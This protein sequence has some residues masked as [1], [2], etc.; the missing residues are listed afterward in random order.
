MRFPRAAG[1]TI[2]LSSLRTRRSWG[3]GEI[4]DLAECAAWLRTGGLR[5]LQILPPYELAAGE[6]SPYGAR[7]AFGLDPIYVGLDAVLDLDAGA[8]DR[9][10]GEAGAAELARLRAAPSVEFDAVRAVKGRVLAAAFERFR[11][12]ELARGTDR[13]KAFHAFVAEA[14]EW[15]GD[16]ALYVALR[17]AHASYGWQTWP[18]GERTREPAALARAARDHEARIAAHHY[19]QWIAHEQ[20]ARARAAMRAAGVELMGDLPFVVGTESAD[21]WSHASQ[22]RLG[23]SLG[24]PPDAFSEEGQDWGL[25][26]YDWRAMDEDGLAWLRARTRHAA[27]L[28]DRFRLDHVIGY[29][30]MFVKKAG[31]GGKAEKG[32]FD[33]PDEPDQ[34]ARGRKV[35]Q[36]IVEEA[37][38]AQVIAEDLGVIPPFAREALLELEIPGYRVIP[39][40]RDFE[41]HVYRDPKGYQALSVASW[42]THDTAPINAWWTE[43]KP[44]EREGLSALAGVPVDATDD[45]R[46][47]ALMRTLMAA[48]SDLA[49]VL[50]PE[51]LREAKRINKPGTVTKDN[52]TYRL[53]RP[54]E[55]L[56]EDPSVKAR[57]ARLRELAVLGGRDA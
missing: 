33:P 51:I 32:A 54:I 52:W 21:V 22:F 24:A 1:C 46:W 48:T 45:Q 44:Y 19:A 49:L 14:S 39:W 57:M 29:F 34:I 25:P 11:E 37:R 15:E 8:I 16:L 53:P 28:Y 13:A 18:D 35:L 50:A 20:W 30:R 3:I 31:P 38:G 2:P 12:R 26:P 42:S 41:K 47:D 9:A 55:E 36:A 7:T 6:A 27:R 4:T 43:L 23:E 56:A 5:L 17:E 40:E 10:L